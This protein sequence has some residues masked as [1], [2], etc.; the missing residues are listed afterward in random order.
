MTITISL[1]YTD[2]AVNT[3]DT[4][5]VNKRKHYYMIFRYLHASASGWLRLT[6]CIKRICYVM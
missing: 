5:L 6:T 3:C 1:A 4:L 2:Y